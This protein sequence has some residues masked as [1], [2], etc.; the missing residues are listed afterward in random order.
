MT[1][2]AFQFQLKHLVKCLLPFLSFSLPVQAHCLP[3]EQYSM[4]AI[5]FVVVADDSSGVASDIWDCAGW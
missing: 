3:D 4:Q 5:E 2:D 1:M